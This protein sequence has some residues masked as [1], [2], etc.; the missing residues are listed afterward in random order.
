MASKAF[1]ISKLRKNLTK[2]IQGISS[3]F[4]DPSIWIDTGSY[5]LNYLISGGFYRGV[6]L[7]KVTVFGGQPGSGKSYIVSGNIIRNAQKQG[8]I[9]ILI[10]SENALDEAWLKPLGVDT[11]ESKLL[12][13][14]MAMVDDAAKTINDTIKDYKLIP[15]EDRPPLLFVIDSLGMMLTPSDE[16]QFEE[17]DLKGDMGRKAKALT[18]L[19][20]NCVNKFGELNIGLVAT[21]HS[22]ESQDMFNPDDKISGGL[23]FIYAA[24][25]VVALQKFKLKENKEGTKVADVRGIRSK[26]K[27]MKTR[28]NQPFQEAELKIPWDTG[29]DP[30]TGLFEFFLAKNILSKDGHKYSY[31]SLDNSKHSYYKKDWWDNTNNCLDLVMS[32][33][34]KIYDPKSGTLS[35]SVEDVNKILENADD[36]EEQNV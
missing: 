23:G 31:S 36:M 13:L 11:D 26:V 3:G 17:G 4:K 14:N 18:A 32:E 33:F 7:G 35:L 12:K 8:I 9:P 5:L 24:S 25:I 28:F 30:Y 21:N 27:V 19:V 16:K 10:D 2:N 29:L 22:Y 15:E 20:R 1:D 34:D 6:P